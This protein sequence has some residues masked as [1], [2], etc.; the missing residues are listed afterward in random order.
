LAKFDTNS[1]GTTIVK[2]DAAIVVNGADVSRV[3]LPKLKGK[4][5]FG[6]PPL[7]SMGAILQWAAG[8]VEPKGALEEMDPVD[9]V[10]IGD[11]LFG[12]LR[13]TPVS[14]AAQSA[15]SADTSDGA[16]KSS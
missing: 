6:A 11:F 12:K 5:L 15:E 10:E 3:T 16:A 7:G 2:L 9:A 14:G 13:R 4:H 8:I 1:D